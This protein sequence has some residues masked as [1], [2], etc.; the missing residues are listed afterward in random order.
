M[1]SKGDVGTAADVPLGCR[2]RVADA[3]ET[4]N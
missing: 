2:N 3:R 4:M 1:V